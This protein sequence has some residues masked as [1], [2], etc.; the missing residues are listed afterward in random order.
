[1]LQGSCFRLPFIF[2]FLFILFGCADSS[3]DTTGNGTPLG[4]QNN[5]KIIVG[6]EL[7]SSVES[8]DILR[9]DIQVTITNSPSYI[10]LGNA[11]ATRSNSFSNR[12]SWI[13]SI[14]NT[15]IN[16]TI[17]PIVLGGGEL[18]END[19]ALI[20]TI[21]SSVEGVVKINGSGFYQSGCLLP[22]Q[23]GYI[24][25]IA[26]NAFDIS[27]EIHFD[28]IFAFANN[29][30]EV[31]QGYEIIPTSY[32]L[33]TKYASLGESNNLSNPPNLEVT[34]E[35]GPITTLLY[36]T[37]KYILLDEDDEPLYWNYLF[38]HPGSISEN[39]GSSIVIEASETRLTYARFFYSGNANKMKPIV[40]FA[41]N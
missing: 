18:R 5:S 21:T 40:N 22:N 13:V 28:N 31:S 9:K 38:N 2:S 19:G 7:G 24:M 6:E 34:I 12:A 1:M 27:A 20:Q 35:N 3:N 10:E 30:L 25:G 41:V 23:T 36:Y 29:N 11:Y 39:L 37:S 16:D 33:R 17:C 15:S 14:K 4:G 8:N 32:Q 26:E